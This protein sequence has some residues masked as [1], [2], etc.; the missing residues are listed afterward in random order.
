M[1]SPRLDAEYGVILSNVIRR[2]R[3]SRNSPDGTG[4][5][6]YR[7]FRH[8]TDGFGVVPDWTRRAVTWAMALI[9]GGAAP[10]DNSGYVGWRPPLIFNGPKTDSMLETAEIEL[11]SSRRSRWLFALRS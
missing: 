6:P 11:Y 8:S 3:C 10:F 5:L 4:G 1:Q 2:R 9:A 7:V